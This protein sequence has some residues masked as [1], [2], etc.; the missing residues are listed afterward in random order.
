M[1]TKEPTRG[2]WYV[3]A[4]SATLFFFFFLLDTYNGALYSAL[5]DQVETV[6]AL[7]VLPTSI[8]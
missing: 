2:P 3:A 7:A 8:H 5:Y 4:P 6:R 1:T